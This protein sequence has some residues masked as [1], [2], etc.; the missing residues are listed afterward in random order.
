MSKQ[1]YYKILGVGKAAT[2]EEIKKAYRALALKYHPDRNPN[3]KEAEAQFKE[4]SEAYEV[5]SDAEKRQQYDQFGHAGMNNQ[6]FSGHNM[7]MNDIFRNFGDIFGSMFGEHAGGGKKGRSA[8]PKAA[9][10]HDLAKDIT[11]TLKESY[12]G[13]KKD[14]SFSHF[15]AC[16]A[17]D[18]KGVK[19]GTSTQKCTTC[20][21]SGE[22]QFQKGFFMYSQTCG[23][24]HGNGY[25]I[26]HPCSTCGGQS[27]VQKYDKFNVTIPEGIF[28]QAELRISGKGD[29]GVF[30][31]PSGDLFVRIHITSDKHFNRVGDDLESKLM[32]TYPQLVFGC[33]VEVEHIDGTKITV[34][35]A[36]GCPVGEK[37]IIPGKGFKKLKSAVHGNMVLI[38]ECHIPTKIDTAA[39]KLLNDYS[40][41]IGTDTHASGSGSISSFFKK[42]LG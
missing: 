25:I 29:A 21:G 23:T 18:H 6:G 12:L 27:R 2:P 9:R 32:L 26:P 14:I 38:T 3:N 15:V 4:A 8:N 10:G 24:C 11:V 28:D 42:F 36:K 41:I 16:E 40:T 35:V 22:M 5:L 13:T 34:K 37:I 39:K 30:G 31:G 7:D 1:D 17:C 33:Q 19:P 20:H